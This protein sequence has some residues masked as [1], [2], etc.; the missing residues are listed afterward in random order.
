MFNGSTAISW[1]P[2]L[3]GPEAMSEDEAYDVAV[4]GYWTILVNWG[5]RD[6]M[7]F[8]TGEVPQGSVI[9]LKAD[10]LENDS[11]GAGTKPGV[12]AVL[13][14]VTGLFTVAWMM[15]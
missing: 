10:T 1:R 5:R 7:S 8:S 11:E 6:P 4:G 14:L 13:V 15:Y 12:D 3:T 9:C 2:D